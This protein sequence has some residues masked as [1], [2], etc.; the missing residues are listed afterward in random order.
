MLEL[1]I[2]A[3]AEAALA[4]GRIGHIGFSFH[5]DTDAFKEIVDGYE[6]WTMCL[7]Q[8]NYMDIEN[9]AGTEGLRYAAS[10]GLAVAIMEPLL[11]G[12][13]AKPPG[14]VRELFDEFDPGVTP[15]DRA[16][17]W[18]WDQPE[19]SVVLSGMSTMDQVEENLRSAD[20]SGV[21]SL[22]PDEKN[23]IERVREKFNER[24]AIQCTACGYCMPC[25]SGVN[26]PSNLELYNDGFVYEDWVAP[27]FK[28]LRWLGESERA[29]RCEHCGECE[30]KCP[31]GLQIGD[32][33]TMVHEKL[34]Q[35][36]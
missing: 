36:G 1:D 33:M 7:M 20:A 16:L 12:S 13:L 35:D 26:I 10:K 4:D 25:P 32:L 17:Q 31:Q 29:E 22:T 19:V 24:A 30:E 14:P 21:G 8:H 9:Q 11:G 3:R 34:K 18:L 23:L 6:G 5:D 28:Y 27:R 15:A 2:P